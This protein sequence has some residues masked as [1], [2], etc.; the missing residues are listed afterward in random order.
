MISIMIDV[1][2][3]EFKITLVF[4]DVKAAS[5]GEI[6]HPLLEG[7]YYTYFSWKIS[8]KFVKKT[9]WIENTRVTHFKCCY[10]II[11]DKI[12]FN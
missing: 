4:L 6:L 11:L 2:N 5:S 8:G 12:L 9:F 1:L 7:N 10:V 3:F